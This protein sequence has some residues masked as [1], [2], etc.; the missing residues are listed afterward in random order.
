MFYVNF[1]A[2]RKA[3]LLNTCIHTLHSVVS[4]PP[5]QPYLSLPVL[6]LLTSHVC[7][8]PNLPVI[9]YSNCLINPLC[10]VPSTVCDHF[11]T[12][13]ISLIYIYIYIYHVCLSYLS[14]G[15]I[16]QGVVTG[17][18]RTWL[19]PLLP[20]IEKYKLIIYEDRPTKHSLPLT[21]LT[22][23]VIEEKLNSQ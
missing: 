8:I 10:P 11:L 5:Y 9:L 3:E 1:T 16:S 17:F 4:I 22:N 23:L 21:Q 14:S 6:S 2:D 15:F 7:P 18:C 13:T 19:V 12:C 20:E